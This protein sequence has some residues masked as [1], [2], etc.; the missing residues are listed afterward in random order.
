M[1]QY[2]VLCIVCLNGSIEPE[3]WNNTTPREQ[4]KIEPE[5]LNVSHSIAMGLTLKYLQGPGRSQKE[6]KSASGT[7]QLYIACSVAD[8]T[9]APLKH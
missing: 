8:D 2:V 6:G 4:I 9:L 5:V 7:R 3:F 1:R